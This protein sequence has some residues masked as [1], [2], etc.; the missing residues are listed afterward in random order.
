MEQ[1]NTNTS[2]ETNSTV[3]SRMTRE[4]APIVPSSRL[5]APPLDALS[6]KT[7]PMEMSPLMTMMEIISSQIKPEKTSINNK[8]LREVTKPMLRRRC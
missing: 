1:A 2:T 3:N 4:S 5:M 8:L 6:S 7:K